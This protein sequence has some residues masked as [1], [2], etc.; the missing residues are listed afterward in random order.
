MFVEVLVNGHGHVVAYAEHCAKSVGAKTHVGMLTHVFETLPLLLHGIVGAAGAKHFNVGGLHFY[1]LSG[2]LALNQRALHTEAG[3][4]GD[5]FEEFGI[6]LVG[7]G[8]YLH[9]VDGAAVVEGNKVHRL[10]AT[11]GAHPS[12]YTYR[13]A[14]GCALE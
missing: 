6:K 4:R 9:V 5:E 11:T 10:A 1:V 14:I 7:V 3:T 8:H 12:F 2:A 13:A